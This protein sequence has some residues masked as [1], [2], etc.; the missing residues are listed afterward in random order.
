MSPRT[1]TIVIA[2]LTI[3]PA[4]R[5]ETLVT[6]PMT[7]PVKPLCYTPLTLTQLAELVLPEKPRILGEVISTLRVIIIRSGAL[8]RSIEILGRPTTVLNT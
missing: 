2:S 1:N 7:T 3:K 6:I 4:T 8:T 5:L